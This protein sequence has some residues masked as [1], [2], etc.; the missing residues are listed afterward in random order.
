MPC[1]ELRSAD[2]QVRFSRGDYCAGAFPAIIPVTTLIDSQVIM[3]IPRRI[4]GHL[5]ERIG[6]GRFVA[7][8]ILHLERNGGWVGIDA[9][10]CE[11]CRDPHQIVFV[12]YICH[13]HL[14]LRR[15]SCCVT[16]L[17][18]LSEIVTLPTRASEIVTPPRRASEIVTPPGISGDG[19]G[20]MLA[21]GDTLAEGETDGLTLGLGETD[22]LGE[23]LGDIEAD[24]EILADGEI[25]EIG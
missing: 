10:N 13:K 18:S 4:L 23:M 15:N 6:V 2:Q 9:G 11:S 8:R 1:L 14:L 24:G 3:I 7:R 25:D 17:L 20:D 19:L 16:Y 21:D 5:P 12:V 22:A